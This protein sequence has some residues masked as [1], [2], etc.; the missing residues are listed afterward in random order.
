MKKVLDAIM[1]QDKIEPIYYVMK[2]GVHDKVYNE[3]VEDFEPQQMGTYLQYFFPKGMLDVKTVPQL[4]MM[5]ADCDVQIVIVCRKDSQLVAQEQALSDRAEGLFLKIKKGLAAVAKIANKVMRS[6]LA[7]LWSVVR[8]MFFT[9]N[10]V[11]GGGTHVIT[12]R[13]QVVQLERNSLADGEVVST[14]YNTLA[15]K[16][17]GTDVYG[18]AFLCCVP[19]DSTNLLMAFTDTVRIRLEEELNTIFEHQRIIEFVPSHTVRRLHMKSKETEQVFTNAIRRYLGDEER[20]RIEY[21]HINADESWDIHYRSISGNYFIACNQDASKLNV[22][23]SIFKRIDDVTLDINKMAREKLE[24]NEALEILNGRFGNVRIATSKMLE[25]L[26]I[27]YLNE[28]Q[29]EYK[30]AIPLEDFENPQEYTVLHSRDHVYVTPY[31]KHYYASVELVDN[32]WL[33]IDLIEKR[34]TVQLVVYREVMRKIYD[35]SHIK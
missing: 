21:N 17:V 12:F 13:H 18:E 1:V 29:Y 25:E 14:R 6:A 16:L 4:A 23:V 19:K 27:G 22:L 3:M 33:H 28:R 10:R 7:G 26:I 20:L 24:Y 15:S 31:G 32:T 5:G 30:K 2:L 11:S 35:G 9:A 34:K 8:L